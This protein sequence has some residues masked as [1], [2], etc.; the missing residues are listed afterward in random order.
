[1][2]TRMVKMMGWMVVLVAMISFTSCEVEFRAW[3]DGEVCENSYKDTRA[4]CSRTWEESWYDNGVRYTQKLDFYDNRT[5]KDRLRIEYR[6]GYVEEEVYYFDWKWDG[7]DCVRME[8]GYKDVS[9]LERIWISNNTLTGYLD[10]VEV[11]F[12]GRL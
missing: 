5:G 3:Y 4:L 12:K 1:M 10:N 2:K 7:K 6:D 9:F 8:Y 11:C